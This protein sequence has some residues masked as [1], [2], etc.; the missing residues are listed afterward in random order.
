MENSD[1]PN[2]T[3]NKLSQEEESEFKDAV[4]THDDETLT[5]GNKDTANVDNAEKPIDL[6]EL[7]KD[8]PEE[9]KTDIVQ[10]VP[11]EYDVRQNYSQLI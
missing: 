1:I 9:S 7:D 11:P 8:V 10:E 4:E 5:N 3:D 2:Q 6:A